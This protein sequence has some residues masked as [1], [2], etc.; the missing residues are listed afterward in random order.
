LSFVYPEPLILS[1]IPVGYWSVPLTPS[2]TNY[3]TSVVPYTPGAWPYLLQ[4][5]SWARKHSIHVIIDLHGAPGSQNGY[6]NSGQRTPDP[7]W[8]VNPANVSRTLDIIKYIATNLGDMVDVI[9]LLNEPAGFESSDFANVV[10]QYWSDGYQAVRNTAGGGVK[11]MIGNAFLSFS[12]S[13]L[14]SIVKYPSDN[15]LL[16]LD[17]LLDVSGLT[18]C[19]HGLCR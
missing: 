17:R 6:D 3:T 4:A 1:S 10:R 11:V 5:V 14:N 2:D 13:N 7:V 15:K 19:H 12:V 9:E 18:G 16:D 8:A